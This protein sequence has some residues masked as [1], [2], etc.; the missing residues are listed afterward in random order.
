[1]FEAELKQLQILSQCWRIIF[2]AEL[3]QVSFAALIGDGLKLV[4]KPSE[5]RIVFSSESPWHSCVFCAN[6]GHRLD[7]ISK[8]NPG[9]GF[10]NSSFCCT[11]LNDT[12]RNT[13]K[14][15]LRNLYDAWQALCRVILL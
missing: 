12:C 8:G 1:M 4:P 14:G 5:Y 11:P 6:I 2:E 3:K 10:G 13:W 15:K 9:H 7:S